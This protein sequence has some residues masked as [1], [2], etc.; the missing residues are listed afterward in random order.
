MLEPQRP[1]SV[2]RWGAEP[3]HWYATDSGLFSDRPHICLEERFWDQA[4]QIATDRYY[5]ID[6]AT[7]AVTEYVNTRRLYSQSEIAE[8]LRGAG[9]EDLAFHA[10][11]TGDEDGEDE[12]VMVVCA[13][14]P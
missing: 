6:A 5:I 8:L 9:F 7:S 10:S 12:D 1:D 13:R 4:E 14:K 3:P 2:Q 11:L